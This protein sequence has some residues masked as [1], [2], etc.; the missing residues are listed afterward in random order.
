MSPNQ[1]K[2]NQFIEQKER[3]ATYTDMREYMQK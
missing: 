3:S 1:I 2:S